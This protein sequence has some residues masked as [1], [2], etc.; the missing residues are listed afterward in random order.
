MTILEPYSGPTR[1]QTRLP[2]QLTSEDRSLLEQLRLPKSWLQATL[3]RNTTIPPEEIY[4]STDAELRQ[5]A[6]LGDDELQQLRAQTGGSYWNLPFQEQCRLVGYQYEEVPR[7]HIE[8]GD[9]PKTK[10]RTSVEDLAARH[11]R[12]RGATV[13]RAEGKAFFLLSRVA[14]DI[15]E[16]NSAQ[17]D[18][19]YPPRPVG[20][21]IGD[22]W[23]LETLDSVLP[24]ITLEHVR[25]LFNYWISI[26]S[27]A[28]WPRN[29]NL[30]WTFIEALM[31]PPLRGV[32]H[33]LIRYKLHRWNGMG[34]PDLTLINGAK[35][36]FVEVKAKGDSFTR[37]Q[38]IWA[39]NFIRPLG[40][41][42]N[43]LRVL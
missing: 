33:S 13:D 22:K 21:P 26:P 27:R 15:A 25:A 31:D 16:P 10:P 19:K 12:S 38:P 42:A 24:A 35:V 1:P 41:S 43:V 40:L 18:A 14:Q 4:W 8:A 28:L 20:A 17:P 6:P 11:F 29:P 9:E 37:L 30:D 7:S 3:S 32:V 39:R 34:W 36:S 2:F 23:H 5:I